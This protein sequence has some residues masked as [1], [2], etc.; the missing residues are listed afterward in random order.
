MDIFIDTSKLAEIRRWLATGIIDGVTTN[1]SIMLREGVTDVARETR[2]I[3]AAVGDRPVSVEVVTNAHDEMLKQA[4]QFARLASNI[5]V[6]IP[7]VNEAGD[8]SLEV[9]HQL[10]EEGIRVNVTAC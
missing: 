10:E 2:A 8:P 4:R 5:V 3:A 7:I 1:P 6:K 9:V